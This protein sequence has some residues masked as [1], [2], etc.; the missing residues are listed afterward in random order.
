MSTYSNAADLDVK[1][2]RIHESMPQE[3]YPIQNCRGIV[4]KSGGKIIGAFISA[5]RH[6]TFNACSL[7]GGSF[8]EVTGKTFNDWLADKVKAD[9]NEERLSRLEPEQI[10]EEYFTALNKKDAE[11]A[12][13]CISKKTLLG[14]L[15][16]NMR[17]EKLHND[18][19][20]LLLTDQNFNN[21]KSAKLLKIELLDEP[22][23]NTKK[24]RV[25]VDLR[26]NKEVSVSN[27][28]QYWDCSMVYESF[29]TGWKI[30]GFG[31]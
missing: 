29:Q 17:N 30:E 21:L 5:G 14:E 25:T 10:I 22:N 1:I 4:V 9:T 20:D 6:N 18:A 31:H 16:T 12:E 19:I 2:Y 26:Y 13:C 15:T 3:F 23:K 27:G 7:K 28:K 11:T 24:F 8:D